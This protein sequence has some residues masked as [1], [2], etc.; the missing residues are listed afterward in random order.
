MIKDLSGCVD[1][2]ADLSL[3]CADMIFRFY[4]A[5]TRFVCKLTDV[6]SIKLLCLFTIERR[7]CFDTKFGSVQFTSRVNFLYI[8]SMND[9]NFSEVA[10]HS[11]PVRMSCV[12]R[13]SERTLS[14]WYKQVKSSPLLETLSTPYATSFRR[15]FFTYHHAVNHP[16]TNI[17]LS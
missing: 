5:M 2:H 14:C 11:L 8:I 7:N 4:C 6:I 15:R 10:F 12:V 17:I 3:C 9:S 1:A 16:H 13:Y